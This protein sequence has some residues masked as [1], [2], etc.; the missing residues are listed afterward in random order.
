M[1]VTQDVHRYGH[2]LQRALDYSDGRVKLEDLQGL[3]DAGRLVVFGN[4]RA[5]IGAEPL[6]LPGGRWAL[7][8]SLAGGEMDAALALYDECESAARQAG[9]S[10]VRVVGRDGWVRALKSRGF[11]HVA[12]LLSKELA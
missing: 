8:V 1:V 6:K 12:T 10:E 4:D 9:A 11:S 5:A 3:V 2:H 7:V